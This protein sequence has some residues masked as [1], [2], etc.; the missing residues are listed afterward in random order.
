M[1]SVS[2]AEPADH[3]APS[4]HKISNNLSSTWI[5][6]HCKLAQGRTLMARLANASAVQIIWMHQ[7]PVRVLRLCPVHLWTKRLLTLQR[8]ARLANLRETTSVHVTNQMPAIK[9]KSNA[10]YRIEINLRHEVSAINSCPKMNSQRINIYLYRL[11]L[12]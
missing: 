2:T 7:F 4:P 9:S 8:Q 5:T 11:P 10:N 12:Q 1:C 6:N 3:H